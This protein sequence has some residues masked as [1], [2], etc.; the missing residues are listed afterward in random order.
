M[1]LR[2]SRLVC[3]KRQFFDCNWLPWQRPL[4]YRKKT[5]GLIICHSIPTIWCKDCEN[6]SSGSWDTSAPCEHIRYETKLVAMATSLEILKK[7]RSVIYTKNA[8]IWYKNCKNRTWFVFCLRH[9]IGCYDVSKGIKKRS[10]SRKFTQ[11]PFIWWKD[12]ENRSS[13]SWDNLSQI[14]KRRRN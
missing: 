1:A 11:I 2:Q 4:R 8:F 14:I 10:G 5:A 7:I 13:R 3:N 6:Q 12:R 9:K